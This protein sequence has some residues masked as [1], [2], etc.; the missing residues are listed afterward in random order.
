[1]NIGDFIEIKAQVVDYGLEKVKVR[2]AGYL[3]DKH[4]SAERYIWLNRKDIKQLNWNLLTIKADFTALI[5][6]E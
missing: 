4:N 3:E 2:I 5:E 6:A 1:M